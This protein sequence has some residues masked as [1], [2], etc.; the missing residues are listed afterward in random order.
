M[1]LL[2]GCDANDNNSSK[3]LS[4]RMK[5]VPLRGSVWLAYSDNRSVQL[6]A[7]RYRAVV[8]TSSPRI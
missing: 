7:T 8:L 3:V 1:K 4:C 6:R 5:L 2:A